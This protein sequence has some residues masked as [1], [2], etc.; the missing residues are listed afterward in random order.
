MSRALDLSTATRR[1]ARFIALTWAS[2][3][4]TSWSPLRSPAIR[5]KPRRV[6]SH[7]PFSLAST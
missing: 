6:D 7:A 2:Y 5:K 4:A 3:V 1:N